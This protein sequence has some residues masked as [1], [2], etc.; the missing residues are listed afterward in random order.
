MLASC[1]KELMTPITPDNVAIV[2]SY[3]YAGDSVITIKISKILPFSE[4]TL[5]ATE[6][7]S[8][9]HPQINGIDLTETSSG[10]YTLKLSDK[11]IQPGESYVL[12]FL[13]AS[14]T[15][16]S[17][18]IIPDKPLN[19]S[20]SSNSIY[21]DRVTSAGGGMPSG[22]PSDLI[23]SWDN[24]DESYYYV[25]IQ[26]METSRDYINYRSA[27][28]D[29]SDT[30]SISPLNTSETRLGTRDLSFFGTYRIILFKVNDDFA[31]LYQQSEVNSNN[32]ANPVSTIKNGFGVFT[33]MASDTTYLEVMEN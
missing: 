3:L 6:Y 2:E 14:D 11:Q 17:T 15:V 8:G 22:P 12:K 30:T 7:I 25:L 19:F 28:L 24:P 23:L 33:G 21:V 29:L 1:G 32:I 26:Y 31:D 10:I 9:L 27:S 18:T 16:S 13:Y 20:I 4:D 5:D